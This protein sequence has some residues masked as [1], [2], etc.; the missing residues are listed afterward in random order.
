MPVRRR[1]NNL[2][3]R[4]A[5]AARK[6]RKGIGKPTGGLNQAVYLFKRRKQDIVKLDGTSESGGFIVNAT[7]TEAY[8]QWTFKLEDLVTSTDFVALF[9]RYKINGVKVELAFS[10]TGSDAQGYNFNCNRQLQIMTTKNSSGKTE[11]LTN[12]KMLDTQAMKKRL[13]LNGGK[14]ITFYMPVTQLSQMYA[15]AIN[16]DYAT[17]KPKYV[18]TAENTIQHYGLNMVL[19]RLDGEAFNYQGSSISAQSIRVT[20]TYY[21]SFKGVE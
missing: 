1:K 5:N 15:S 17:T 13:A 3:I 11:V 4:R 12:E 8:R 19:S 14:P 16:T 6:K 20:T 7:N 10:N 18:S 9:R 21:M 2:R